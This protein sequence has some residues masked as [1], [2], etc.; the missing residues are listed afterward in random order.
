[1]VVLSLVL[2]LQVVKLGA[3][4]SFLACAALLAAAGVQAKSFLAQS[5]ALALNKQ[6]QA[7]L[8]QSELEQ[9]RRSVD[10]LADGLDVAIF[11]CDPRAQILYANLRARDLFRFE[12]PLGRS[13]LAVTLS[14]DL[15]QVV[16]K[17]AREQAPQRAE[18]TFAYP[19]ERMGIAKAWPPK[20]SLGRIFLSVYEVTDLRRLERVRQDFVANVS[21]ELRTP[22][23]VIRAMAETLLDET[24]AEDEVAQKYLSKIMSEVDRLSM[25]SQDLLV[26]SAAESNP[27]RKQIC[28]LAEVVTEVVGQLHAR[29]A[30][31]GLTLE[32]DGPTHLRIN[33]NPAQLTQVALNLIENAINYSSHG[34]VIVR[35][36]SDDQ[37][38]ILEV[39]DSGIGIAFEHQKRVFE[40]FYRIDKGRSR[41]SGGTGLG[42]SIV[43]HIVEAHGGAV[44]VESALNQGSTFTAT[45]PVEG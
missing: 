36:R 6:S 18:L 40:R 29:A 8:L 21:H 1:M 42:L 35:L 37:H 14:H 44:S 43:K 9:Q 5:T 16:F 23:T 25:I 31:K 10:A 30:G 39:Q 33:A 32:Y 41:A 19:D 24:P 7:D 34:G 11:I 20:D 38:A 3:G 4:W 12:D 15:E 17:A 28:D 27:V 13:L 2:F 26:L 22:M 45:L